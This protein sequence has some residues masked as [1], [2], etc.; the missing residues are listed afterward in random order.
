MVYM[1]TF[2]INIPHMLAYIP[3]PRILWD[4]KT[5]IP[6][7]IRSHG[8]SPSG[9]RHSRPRIR[10]TRPFNHKRHLDQHS[11]GI[12]SPKCLQNFIVHPTNTLRKGQWQIQVLRDLGQEFHGMYQTWITLRKTGKHRN[13]MRH[14]KRS[15]E[16]WN[17]RKG[18]LLTHADSAEDHPSG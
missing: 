9:L 15:F 18:N 2:T 7:S 4:S 13:I 14:P 16:R 1:V 6:T 17:L 8:W 11:R 5:I 3:A 10:W 12:R